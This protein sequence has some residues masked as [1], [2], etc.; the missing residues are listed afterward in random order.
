MT[1]SPHECRFRVLG[2]RVSGL[3]FRVWGCSR[4][5]EPR[6]LVGVEFRAF[7][8]FKCDGG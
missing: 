8:C 7:E 4:V 6:V 1:L 2:L 3:G 5:A